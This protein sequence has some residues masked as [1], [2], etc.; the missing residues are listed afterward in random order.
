MSC[1]QIKRME[2]EARSFSADKSRALLSKVRDYKADLAA[3]RTD[4]KKVRIALSLR[5][6]CECGV[7]AGQHY[8][9]CHL[10]WLGTDLT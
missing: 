3:L 6:V 1:L 10:L 7:H 8:G 5:V 4:F 9:R 2:M